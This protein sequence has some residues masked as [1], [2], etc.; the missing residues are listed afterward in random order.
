MESS[1]TTVKPRTVLAATSG[2]V[3]EWY[4]F[5][6]YS[7]LAPI[8]GHVFF[9]SD[10][11]LTSL[12]SAFAVLA[13][14]Y[15]ARPLGSV[16]FGHIGD[17]IG[18]KPAMMASVMLMGLGSFLIAVLP[19]PAQIGVIASV[20]LVL[21]RVVQ[22]ISVAGEYTRSGV[23]L[24]EQAD[25]R[26]RG[27]V[28]GWIAFAMMLGCVAG[29]GIP[30]L[31]G[32]FLTDAQIQ[33]WGW[34]IPFLLGSAIALY[35]AVLRSNITGSQL[36]VDAA[37]RIKSPIGAALRN[38]WRLMAQM[39]VLL[40]PSAVIYFV[41]FVYAASYLTGQMHFTTAQALDITTLN[42]IV[43]ALLSVGVG[44]LSDRFG[45]RPL[46][47]FGAIGTLVFG[48][49]LWWMMHQDNIYLV[50]LGQMGFSAFNAIGWGL[51][52]TVLVEMAPP[53][54]RCSTVSMG[55]NIAMAAFGGTTPIIAT[56]LVSRT[57]DDFTPVYYIMAATVASLFVI[58]RIPT[59][60]AKATERRTT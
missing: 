38:H 3:L 16:I 51:S 58:V 44:R 47:L 20:L 7:F 56:Y 2:N 41:I 19:T 27:F 33:A 25:Q 59:L 46:F 34:R 57:G 40:I 9:P 26:S 17:R 28:G 30:A 13:V 10:D 49:P 32:T 15:F 29:S 35:S 22:G 43:I 31:L 8:L 45:R 6:S 48:W 14:G 23:L 11:K 42:L 37:D 18:R 60:I 52:I 53:K 12:L 36:L 24:I 54:L 5:T 55:Y 39:V 50:F 21:I 4:D 1:E